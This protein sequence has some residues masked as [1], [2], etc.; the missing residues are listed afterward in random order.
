[1]NELH[2]NTKGNP[3]FLLSLSLPLSLSAY[4][5]SFIILPHSLSSHYPIFTSSTKRDNE[6]KKTSF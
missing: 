5:Y 1:M 6:E 2:I 3:K 4:S